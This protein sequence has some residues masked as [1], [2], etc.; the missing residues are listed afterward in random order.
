MTITTSKNHP[1]EDFRKIITA[2]ACSQLASLFVAHYLVLQTI[3][4]VDV[5]LKDSSTLKEIQ[6]LMS[7]VSP[8]A[9][10]ST[11]LDPSTSP[12]LFTS[13]DFRKFSTEAPD[14]YALCQTP[15]AQRLSA[16]DVYNELCYGSGN[17]AALAEFFLEEFN[18]EVAGTD[19]TSNSSKD[20][21]IN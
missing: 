20:K 4:E 21:L 3:E 8:R 16:A 7:Q 2:K 5:S 18:K 1:L 14:L 6:D 17:V 13:K 12:D 11:F 19:S 10:I 9:I 15:E